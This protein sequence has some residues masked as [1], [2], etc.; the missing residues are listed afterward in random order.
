[1]DESQ[2]TSVSGQPQSPASA[3]APIVSKPVMIFAVIVVVLIVGVLIYGF[4]LRKNNEG[5]PFSKENADEITDTTT[6]PQD[7]TAN[8]NSTDNIQA[9]SQSYLDY[10]SAQINTANK[11]KLILFFNADWCLTCS[12]LDIDILNNASTIPEELM[13]LKVDYDTSTELNSKY[14]VEFPSTFVL[15]DNQ[16]N[17]LKRW[18]G[19]LTLKDLIAQTL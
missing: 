12:Q 8:E 15:I 4:I 11:S 2:N 10:S 5:L 3:K 1:M 16:E 9:D 14:N 17:E 18:T 6:A 7:L 13:I 19:S